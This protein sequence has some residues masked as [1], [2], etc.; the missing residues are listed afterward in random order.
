MRIKELFESYNPA[1]INKSKDSDIVN[2]R[3]LVE[4]VPV[5][6]L[7]KLPGNTLR[8]SGEEQN[9][10]QSD[11]ASNGFNEPLLIVVGKLSRTAKLGEGNHRLAA[12]IASG[13]THVPVRVIVGSEYGTDKMP[14]G[15]LDKDLIPVPDQYFTSDAKPS[16]VFKSLQGKTI[17]I[18]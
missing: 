18:F 13:Y 16:A 12:A 14:K 10:L 8:R 4:L 1:P 2:Y 11:I 15:T 3:K 9:E 5:D 7:K 6:W 17:D